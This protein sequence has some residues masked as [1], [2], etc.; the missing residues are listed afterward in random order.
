MP[1]WAPRNLPESGEPDAPY[2]FLGASQPGGAPLPSPSS[3]PGPAGGTPPGGRPFEPF[4]RPGPAARPPGPAHAAAG[5]GRR[6]FR[7]PQRFG[8]VLLGPLAGAVGLVLLTGLGAYALT[9]TG[10]ECSG[11]EALS[12]GV[13]A[14]PEIAPAVIRAARRFNDARHEVAGKC[15]RADVRSADPAAVATLL[16]GKGVSGITEKPDVWIPDS[17]LWTSLVAGSGRDGAAPGFTPL[18]GMASTPIVLAMP[19]ALALQ[20]RNLG[21][22]AQPSWKD[23]LAAAGTAA[24]AEQE[25]GGARRSAIPP[26]L[27]RLQVP[28]PDRTATGMGVLVLADALVGG[29]PRGQALFTGAVRTFREGIVPSVNAEFAVLGQEAG[30]RYPVALAPEQAVYSYNAKRPG[31]LAAAVYPA[32]GTVFLDHPV[33]V[34]AR[35]P[36][37]LNAGRLLGR[38]LSSVTTREDVRRLGFR[39]PDGAA[40]AGFTEKTGLSARPPKALPAPDADRVKRI[41]QRWAQ[42]SLS[43]RM[44]SIIDVSGSMDRRIAPGASRLQSTIRTAQNG[45]SL[46]PDDSELGQWVFSTRLQGGQDWRELV[47]VGPLNERLGSAT[48]RQL[49]LSAFAQIRVKENGGTGLYETTIAAFDHM[50]RTYKPEYVNSILLWTDGKNQDREGPSLDETL[51][52]IRRAYDS[53]RPVQINMFGLGGGVDVDELRRIARLTNGD[54]YVAE[55]PGQVQALFL[56]ALSQRVCEPDC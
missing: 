24:N 54:A 45:L 3:S 17:S 48:R 1:E 13:A 36:A 35:D 6:R 22:P 10:D 32:E 34:L 39:S 8:G 7:P 40:Q 53:E 46:L 18:G 11:D 2:T 26:R 25:P 30:D 16:S 29:D 50:K 20:L 4:E 47:S 51:K 14:A 42:L 38:E 56:K 28:D 9:S 49:V 41:T 55:T 15:A 44:L 5:Q 37:K 19:S 33:T 52:H 43:I 27:I 12:I 21:A 31:E 23:L